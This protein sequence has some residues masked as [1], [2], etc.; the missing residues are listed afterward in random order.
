MISSLFF[1]SAVIV[2]LSACSGI[3]PDK[4]VVRSTLGNGLRVV[5]V[6]NTTAPVV[7]VQMNYLAG[8]NESTT[9]FPGTAH[10]LEHMMF[11]GSPG[12]SGDQINAILTGDGGESNAFT[13]QTDTRYISTVPASDL[14]P[15]L[16]LEAL[17][18]RGIDCDERQWEL[19]RSAN[20]GKVT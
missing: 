20:R 5:I 18:M 4:N 16:R 8:S 9:G 12:L 3:V 2:L 14:E 13:S 15:M 17:R 19:E 1:H 11:R 10:A 7:T 6:R